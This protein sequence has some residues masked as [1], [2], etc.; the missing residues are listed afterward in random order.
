MCMGAPQWG[1]FQTIFVES[2]LDGARTSGMKASSWRPTAMSLVRQA[3]A[4]NPNC[5]MRT[6]PARKY[7]LD[8][9]SQELFGTQSH[10]PLLAAVSIISPVKGDLVPFVSD[11]PMVADGNAMS[12][13]AEIAEDRRRPPKA[14]LA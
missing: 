9:A 2:S 3:L 12:V 10:Q 4:R 13:T 1:H 6:K 7:M 11:D 8:E 5:R 14:A